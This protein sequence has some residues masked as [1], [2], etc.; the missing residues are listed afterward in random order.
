MISPL[1]LASAS[2]R[3]INLLKA[4]GLTF[5]VLPADVPEL[6]AAPPGT[7]P[8]Q[9]AVINAHAKAAAVAA[10]H[11]TRLVLGADTIVLSAAGVILGKPADADEAFAILS[12]LAGTRHAVITGV[13]LIRCRPAVDI[14]FFEQTLVTMKPLSAARIRDYIRTGEP[15]G[16]AGAFA[17]QETADEF[18]AGIEGDYDNVVGLPTARVI[19][20]LRTL[21]ISE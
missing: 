2:L 6:T 13:A 10:K 5:E 11:P 16:K 7:E 9:V 21:G 1:I 15:F 19:A 3:R 14:R 18:I 4:A 8:A 17:I 20:A 12:Q